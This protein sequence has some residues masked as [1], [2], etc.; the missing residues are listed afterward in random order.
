LNLLA[1]F[2]DNLTHGAAIGGNFSVSLL[3]GMA[4]LAGIII[5]EIPHEMED[6]P[7]LL[8]SGFNRWQ[9]IKAQMLTR[10][11]VFLVLQFLFSIQIQFTVCCKFYFFVKLIIFLNLRYSLG[12]II[13]KWCTYLCSFS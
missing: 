9:A 13:Y 5:H 11:R 12:F 10:L 3:V 1:N 8:K 7:I 6:L 2:V 4:T